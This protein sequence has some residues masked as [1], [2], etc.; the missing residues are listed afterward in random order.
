M[1]EKT[2][3]L[4]SRTV[5]RLFCQSFFTPKGIKGKETIRP[6]TIRPHQMRIRGP[7]PMVVAA[8]AKRLLETAAAI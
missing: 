1:K 6:H 8:V 5:F 7:Q 4:Y 3:L 2:V